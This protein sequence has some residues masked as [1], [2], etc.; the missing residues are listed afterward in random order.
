[1]FL[2]SI[3]HPFEATISKEKSSIRSSINLQEKK[4]SALGGFYGFKLHL[5]IYDKGVLFDFLLTPGNVDD[6]ELLK[7]RGFHKR[8]FGKLFGGTGYISK[9]LF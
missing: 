4:K 3:L 8:I 2:L 7:H 9:N 1:M 6:R 5:I